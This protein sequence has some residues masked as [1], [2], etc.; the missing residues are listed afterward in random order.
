M[1]AGEVQYLHDLDLV[2]SVFIKALRELR[3][4]LLP[5]NNLENFIND[6]CGNIFE[7]RNIHQRL[8]EVLYAR[9]REEGPIIKRIGDL[10]LEAAEK[11]KYAYPTYIGHQ[12]ISEKRLKKEME[13][14]IVFRGVGHGFLLFRGSLCSFFFLCLLVAAST[15]QWYTS[16]S[17]KP[18]ELPFGTFAKMACSARGHP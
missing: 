16:R 17:P 10:Y 7:L 15:V 11:I 8:L 9:Q 5:P 4:P 12:F 6:I 3:I 1:F 14:N 13:S 18:L 2:E